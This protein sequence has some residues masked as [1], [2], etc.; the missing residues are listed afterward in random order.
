MGDK[1]GIQWTDATAN[2]V[3]GCSR[4][5][6]GCRHCYAEQ[7]AAT[8]LRHTKRY[9]GLAIV[10]AKGTPQWTGEVRLDVGAIEQ[11]LRWQK[12][13]RVFLT[14]MGDPFHESLSNEQIAALFGLMAVC[15]QHTFQVLTKRAARMRAWF[16]WA[17]AQ[18]EDAREDGRWTPFIRALCDVLDDAKIIERIQE[19][20]VARAND[21]EAW[22][23]SN[24][25]LGVSIEHQAA[26]NER[27]P[28]LLATPA[29]VRFLSCEPLLEAVDLTNI[30]IPLSEGVTEHWDALRREPDD[31]LGGDGPRIDWVIVGGESGHGARTCDV[32]WVRSIVEQCKAAEVPVFVKQ[33]GARPVGDWGPGKAPREHWHIARRGEH[34]LNDSHGGDPSEWPSDLRVRE[35]PA[36][37]LSSPK[38]ELTDD[39]MAS[40][41]TFE[42]H[43][44]ATLKLPRAVDDGSTPIARAERAGWTFVRMSMCSPRA[45]CP[46]CSSARPG[47]EPQVDGG[48]GTL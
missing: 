32:S 24:V 20:G 39:R 16:A 22:P 3:V 7:L 26:A 43:C 18:I 5:S 27:V 23:L 9:K 36:K 13:R 1:S 45:V 28:E 17:A 29:A 47:S 31:E 2:V 44:G 21:S 30:E 38:S 40:L 33:L 12:P 41:V 6:D 10:T 35:L 25:E 46:C 15:P 19:D 4:V 48:R 8:R 34:A 14:A 37:G 11:V 42:C